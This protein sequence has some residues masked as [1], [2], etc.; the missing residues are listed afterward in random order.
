MDLA[1]LSLGALVLVVVLSCT[2]RG[3]PGVVAIVL[4]WI[5]A[6]CPDAAGKT[7]G[8]KALAM[9]FNADL[10][11][12]LLGV[13]LLFAQAEANGTLARVAG[14][15]QTLCRGNRGL[16][17]VMF[18]LLAAL[19]GT[20]GPGNIA[21]AGLLA[22]VAMA[23]AARSGIPPL[24]MALM[25]G[26]GAI[27]STLSPFTAAGVTAKN[28]LE[29]MDLTG[30]EWRIYAANAGANALVAVAG[31]LL[32]GG[33]RLFVSAPPATETDSATPSEQLAPLDWRHWLTL[34]IVATLV[35]AVVFAKVPIGYGAFAGATLVSLLGLAD[36]RAAFAKVPWGVIVMVTGVSVLTAMMEKT[37]GLAKFAELIGLISTPRTATGV[38]ALVTGIVSIYSS[39]T[40]VVLPAFLPM[41]KELAAAEPGTS[42]L[43]LALAVLVGGNLVDM[44]P[45]STIGALCLAG[46]P[47]ESDRRVLYRQLLAWGFVLALVGAAISWLW[48]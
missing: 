46:A 45:L 48:F 19:I 11:L 42:P 34:A 5:V 13:S 27:A 12:T 10:F 14:W 28:I 17:P 22:P 31:Y 39:T 18:F 1:W 24:L 36:E 33:W 2:A 38:V 29:G 30:H 43:A 8:L 7:I 16:V 26:H 47:H 40:G 41:V 23:A 15:A 32:L 4:A 21:V 44:S 35:A 9:G 20:A 6:I 3:N 37:G 25:V